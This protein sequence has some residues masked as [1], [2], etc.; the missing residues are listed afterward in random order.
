MTVLRN[1]DVGV[2]GATLSS[3]ALHATRR[4][5][6][7]N[8]WYQTRRSSRRRSGSQSLVRS[9]PGVRGRSRYRC[10]LR[11]EVHPAFRAF[12]GSLLHHLRVH[13]TDVRLPRCNRRGRGRRRARRVGAAL[14][15][16]T[17][18]SKDHCGD[19]E[20]GQQVSVC[21]V[22]GQVPKQRP[23][24]TTSVAIAGNWAA[25]SLCGVTERVTNRLRS[26]RRGYFHQ[27]PVASTTGT[28]AVLFP[29]FGG[30][31]PRP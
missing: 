8:R 28:I 23:C 19:A 31:E 20:N 24:H 2:G 9:V 27:R 17:G 29:E 15:L 14:G 21:L 3:R 18:G 10:R 11:N 13:R 6:T 25:R 1:A 22:H 5:A 30:L 7:N 26:D 16:R 12:S 4:T